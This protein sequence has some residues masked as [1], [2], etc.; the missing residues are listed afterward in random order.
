MRLAGFLTNVAVTTVTTMVFE[1]KASI[2]PVITAVFPA[3]WLTSKS[4]VQSTGFV[5]VEPG[6]V[7]SSLEDI[8]ESDRVNR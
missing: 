7:I 6:I 4:I 3:R 5:G 8:D 2:P 1:M